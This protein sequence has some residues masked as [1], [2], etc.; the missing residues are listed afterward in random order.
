MIERRPM[1]QAPRDGT[2]ILAQEAGSGKFLY[3][4]WCNGKWQ[5]ASDE[6]REPALEYWIVVK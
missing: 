1:D 3:V 2:V 4:I 6:T 5:S